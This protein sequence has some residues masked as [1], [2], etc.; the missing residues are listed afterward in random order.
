MSSAALDEFLR[1]SSDT[2]RGDAFVARKLA[3]VAT[4]STRRSF[5]AWVGRGTLAVMGGAFLGLWN[6]ESAWAACG[7]EGG[8]TTRLSCLCTELLGSNS[9]PSCCGGFWLSCLTRSDPAACVQNCIGGGTRVM[10]SKLYDC[11]GPCGSCN[12]NASGCD[13]SFGNDTCCHSGYCAPNC[14]GLVKCVRK[15]CPN[16]VACGPCI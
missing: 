15:V 13:P 16:S 8:S 3:Q 6:A 14:S 11:C 2:P 7:G 9:C 1:L 4:G 5:L 12:T 10:Q